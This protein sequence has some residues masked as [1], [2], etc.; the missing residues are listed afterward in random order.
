MQLLIGFL[1]FASQ[2]IRLGCVFTRWLWDFINYYPCNGPKIMLKK[3]PA[4]VREDL[5]WWYKLLS[6]YNG[7][8][9]FDTR[10][11]KTQTL[12]T[13][14]YLYSFGGFY[15]KCFEAWEQT[16]VAPSN[17]FCAIT[18]GKFFSANRKIKKD[19]DDPSIN[20]PEVEIIVLAFQIW[21]PQWKNQQLR[22]FT[23]STT[24]FSFLR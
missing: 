1:S 16:N 11:S 23:D 7:V 3:I 21:A 2:A 14:A 20:V 9:F 8:L 15:F 6:I 17:A 5:E 10:N 12:Y 18:W 19:L 22:V 4:L 24:A 13:N